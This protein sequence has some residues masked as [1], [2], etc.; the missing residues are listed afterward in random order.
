MNNQQPDTMSLFSF[1]EHEHTTDLTTMQTRRINYQ[2]AKAIIEPNHYLG[3]LGSTVV[4]FG[5]FI[6]NEI[7]GALTFGTIPGPNAKGI[8]GEEHK[9]KV[10]ELTRLYIHD[11]VGRN[12][13]S[14]FMGE[15]FKQ[16]KPIAMQKGGIILISYAD[17]A[18]NH[19]GVIYQATNWFYTGVSIAEKVVTETG[20][21]LH[22]RVASD[23]RRGMSSA[24][25]E[26]IKTKPKHR[27]IKFIGNK[28]QIKD[29][30]QTMNWEIL[31]YPKDN[32][33]N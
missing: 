32:H 4:A 30:K 1:D 3:K 18:A 7:A 6:D 25:L 13:E 24:G 9:H 17:T 33:D 19:V 20:E 14:R 12:A 23:S 8:C 2:T 5:C 27:Y 10:W 29:F 22:S 28:T 31:P 11:W 26:R 15:V 16:L 21:L